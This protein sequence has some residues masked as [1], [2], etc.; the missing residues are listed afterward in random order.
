MRPRI[1]TN[2]SLVPHRM[3]QAVPYLSVR[4]DNQ[5][6]K[7][8]QGTKRTQCSAVHHFRTG[9]ERRA[10][11][12]RRTTTAQMRQ[13]SKIGRGRGIGDPRAGSRPARREYSLLP[14]ALRAVA[15]PVGPGAAVDALTA[16]RGLR[17]RHTRGAL[18][19]RDS[20]AEEERSQ[21][22]VWR[23]QPFASRAAPPP[24]IL[25]RHPGFVGSVRGIIAPAGRVPYGAASRL[26]QRHGINPR[27]LS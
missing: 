27:S 17:R 3:C 7:N 8:R 25:E 11:M 26:Q 5:A 4:Q 21:P 19:D 14:P 12:L 1:F 23:A 13:R 15:I 20:R 22:T 16:G 18:L 2:C 6:T 9:A 10:Q 24:A